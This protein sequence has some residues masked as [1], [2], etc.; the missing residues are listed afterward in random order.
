MLKE[1]M[2]IAWEHRMHQWMDAYREDLGTQEAQLHV[3]QFS[4]TRYKSHHHIP[5]TVATCSCSQH[6]DII[7]PY[8]L[9][10]NHLPIAI[11]GMWPNRWFGK[12]R[13]PPVLKLSKIGLANLI[14]DLKGAV[15]QDRLF[16]GQDLRGPTFLS[17]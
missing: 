10:C 9:I 8:W 15:W 5:K 1:N 12:I 4:S 17:R 14:L 6:L 16:L 7:F 13:T 2:P 11:Y 3:K